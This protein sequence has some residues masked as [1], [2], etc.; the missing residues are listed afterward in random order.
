LSSAVEGEDGE[1]DEDE[2]EEE[3]EEE[4]ED[5]DEG[6]P[7]MDG[8]EDIGQGS[9][10]GCGEGSIKGYPSRDV[11]DPTLLCFWRGT[12]GFFND[13]MPPCARF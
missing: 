2:I 10:E 9:V 11:S 7:S 1:E 12:F 8:R 5:E 4:D 13:S 6:D 3:E